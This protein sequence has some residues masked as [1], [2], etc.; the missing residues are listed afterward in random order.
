MGMGRLYPRSNGRLASRL[1]LRGT[2]TLTARASTKIR[3]TGY[4]ASIV[5]RSF[6]LALER[7]VTSTRPYYTSESGSAWL[8]RV[9]GVNS[10]AYPSK[11][12]CKSKYSP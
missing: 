9:G 10:G 12:L 8:E 7:D 5:A 3:T 4:S 6:C 1:K 2:L 11:C